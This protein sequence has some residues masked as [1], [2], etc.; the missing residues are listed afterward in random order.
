MQERLASRHVNAGFHVAPTIRFT[1]KARQMSFK[2]RLMR[3][4][5]E[6][7]QMERFEVFS[8]TISPGFVPLWEEAGVYESLYDSDGKKAREIS[9]SLAYGLDR[10]VSDENMAT[11]IPPGTGGGVKE[12]VGFLESLLKACIVHPDARV[13]AS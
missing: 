2:I 9:R 8:G 13:E 11:L 6:D 5:E 3:E 7:F 10:I 1:G 4:I 12:A